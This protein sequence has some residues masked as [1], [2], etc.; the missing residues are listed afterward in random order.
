MEAK[1]EREHASQIVQDS[2]VT[3]LQN[4]TEY[5]EELTVQGIVAI[6][7][8][9]NDPYLIIVNETFSCGNEGNKSETEPMQSSRRADFVA[10]TSETGIPAWK[11]KCKKMKMF[12]TEQVENIKGKKSKTVRRQLA[13]EADFDPTVS[14][15]G[16]PAK[17]PKCKKMKIEPIGCESLFSS[18]DALPI[19]QQPTGS[20][21]SVSAELATRPFEI[22]LTRLPPD[23]VA[24]ATGFGADD[25]EDAEW[26]DQKLTELQVKKEVLSVQ[27]AQRAAGGK[28][29]AP[30]PETVVKVQF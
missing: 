9:D 18:G 29:R 14:T 28:K 8:D 12:K 24:A 23:C 25:S 20:P 2:I 5:Q 30:K 16:F 13:G 17:K 19:G 10:E 22:R 4:S 11:A 27:T 1:Q 3:L 7:K 21:S 15:A 6:T 26:Y